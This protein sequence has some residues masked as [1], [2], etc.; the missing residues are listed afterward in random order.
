ME[1]FMEPTSRVAGHLKDQADHECKA[2][3]VIASIAANKCED[4]LK[5]ISP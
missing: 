1:M 5:V 3:Q 2:P 4:A